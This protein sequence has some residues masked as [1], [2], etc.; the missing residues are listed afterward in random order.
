MLEWGG[1]TR[2]HA[3]SEATV[4]RVFRRA[5]G[6]DGGEDALMNSGWTK[7]TALAT[8]FLEGEWERAPQVIWDS[9]VSTSVVTRLEPLLIQD[10]VQDPKQI[11][12]RIGPV[13][14]RGGSRPRSFELCWSHAYGSWSSQEAGSE[15]VR[16][17]RDILNRDY[18]PMPLPD[19]GTGAWTV[20]G[21]ESVLFMDGY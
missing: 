19:G 8:A 5:L 7:V 14:G 18:P 6:V 4:E 1:V 17:L 15:L 9:R 11:F 2:Q 3:F 20:R 12:P 21:V 13:T 16:T 10:D